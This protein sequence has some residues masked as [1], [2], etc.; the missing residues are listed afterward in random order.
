[1][2]VQRKA[3]S[4]PF[5]HD[6]LVIKAVGGKKLFT[7][8]LILQNPEV[9]LCTSSFYIQKLCLLTTRRIY[10]FCT[11]LGTNRVYFLLTAW[12]L[13]AFAKLRIATISFVTSVRPSVCL[14]AWNDSPPTRRTFMKFYICVHFGRL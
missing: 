13:G 4:P 10:V 12:F 9:T 14:S 2:F 1:M 11:D 8:P 6:L 7:F 3:I 5:T